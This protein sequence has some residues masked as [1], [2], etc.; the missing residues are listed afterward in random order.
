MSSFAQAPFE[1]APSAGSYASRSSLDLGV[2]LNAEAR[3]T[4]LRTA[5]SGSAAEPQLSE[6]TKQA[7]DLG[8]DLNCES[9]RL[10]RAPDFSGSFSRSSSSSSAAPA[11]VRTLDSAVDIQMA[12]RKAKSASGLLAK[13]NRLF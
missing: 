10:W 7:L 12:A 11:S 5:S 9:R 13:W 3:S 2:A 8:V 1:R 4:F 6:R